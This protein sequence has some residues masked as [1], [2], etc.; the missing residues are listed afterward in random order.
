M[1]LLCEGFSGAGVSFQRED[2]IESFSGASVS[3]NVKTEFEPYDRPCNDGLSASC[4]IESARSERV[5]QSGMK[6]MSSSL[7]KAIELVWPS[8]HCTCSQHQVPA[9]VV[10]TK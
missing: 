3:S 5:Y 6:D 10:E 8:Q 2:K 7:S 1:G 9:E 4:D